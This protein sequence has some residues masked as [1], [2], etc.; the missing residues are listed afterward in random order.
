MYLKSTVSMVL[1]YYQW[2]KS[3]TNHLVSSFQ[4]F[5]INH[6]ELYMGMAMVQ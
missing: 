5:Q 2:N 1:D 3:F 6:P 4:H